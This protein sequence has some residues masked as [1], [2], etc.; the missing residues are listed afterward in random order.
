MADGL[1]L[2]VMLLIAVLG[3]IEFYALV[4]K[5]GLGCFGR[6]GILGG[7]LL[8]VDTVGSPAVT[9]RRRPRR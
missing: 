8:V 1:F 6:T 2:A 4:E 9:R 5:A 3:L 7:V